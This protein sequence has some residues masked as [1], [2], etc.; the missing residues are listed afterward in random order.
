M[1]E[2]RMFS[3]PLTSSDL[4]LEMPKDA[5][6]LYFHLALDADDDGFINS[7]NK[8]IRCVGCQKSDMEVLIKKG[9]LKLF[10]SGIA[11]IVHWKI[12]NY[13]QKD[14]YKETI[15]QKEKQQLVL[16]G[17]KYVT[18]DEYTQSVSNEDT[19]CVSIL[20]TQ[21][22][23]DKNNE[24][25]NRLELDGI[26]EKIENKKVREKFE[27]FVKMRENNSSPLTPDALKILINKAEKLTTGFVNQDETIIKI[28]EKSIINNYKDIFPIEGNNVQIKSTFEDVDLNKIENNESEEQLYKDW[29]E[30]NNLLDQGVRDAYKNSIENKFKELYHDDINSYHSRKLNS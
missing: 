26:L 30:S 7:Q 5:Q 29:L 15:Y 6:L 25:Q 3:K 11:V 23:L 9:Y 22:R 24:E 10:E 28:L 18:K 16:Y 27:S 14:R 17:K 8:I 1:A 13:I 2:R 4:F 21:D 12:H 19:S 20:E